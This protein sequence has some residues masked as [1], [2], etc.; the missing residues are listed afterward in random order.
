VQTPAGGQVWTHRHSGW[1]SVDLPTGEIVDA[2]V[3]DGTAYVTVRDR[4]GHIGLWRQRVM[5]STIVE[6]LGAPDQI[7]DYVPSGYLDE[8]RREDWHD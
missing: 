1:K 3:F 7:G 8:V 2:A 5:A 6:D 4:T